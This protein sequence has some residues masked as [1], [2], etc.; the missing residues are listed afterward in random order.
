M[1]EQ[2]GEVL[3]PEL[4]VQAKPES[5]NPERKVVFK[6]SE[7]DQIYLLP[8]SLDEYIGPLHIARFISKIIDG[9]DISPLLLSYKGGGTSAYHPAILL[10]I[11]IFGWIRKIYT[12][13]PLAAALTRDVEF[14]WIAERQEPSHMTLN[15]FRKRLGPDIKKVFKEIVKMA[16]DC[17]MIDGSEVFIDHTKMEADANKHKMVWRKRVEKRLEA[18]DAEMDKLLGLIDRLNDEEEKTYDDESAR[19][20]ALKNVNSAVIDELIKRINGEL[21][22]GEKDRETAKEEKAGL[23]RMKELQG[24]KRI[25]TSRRPIWTEGTA[26]P[27][28][29]RTPWR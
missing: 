20:E 8:E 6:T 10:K 4:P 13:R 28:R 17:R 29:I 9:I 5:E 26:C 24:K 22:T 12:S 3:F 21:K 15:D 16:I 25:T 19:R 18:I 23:R 14:M 27:K 7:K 1:L 2:E 11:W